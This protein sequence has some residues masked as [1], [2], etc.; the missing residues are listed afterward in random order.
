M[1][2]KKENENLVDWALKACV[3]QDEEECEAYVDFQ[4]RLKNEGRWFFF[5][6]SLK[7]G[8]KD[9]WKKETLIN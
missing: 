1:Q 3:P 9:L 6:F 8:E 7:K 2:Q 5:N 4:T